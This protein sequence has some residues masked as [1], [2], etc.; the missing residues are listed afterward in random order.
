MVMVIISFIHNFSRLASIQDV[1]TWTF[2]TPHVY[3]IILI[4]FAT[5]V[6]FLTA[7][8]LQMQLSTPVLYIFSMY[9]HSDVDIM[10]IS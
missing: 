2:T 10:D 3:L 8:A 7:Q 1:L 9:I 4:S 6:Y 5:V